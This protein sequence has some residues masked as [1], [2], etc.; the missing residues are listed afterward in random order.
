[1]WGHS[2]WVRE[3]LEQLEGIKISKNNFTGDVEF[4]LPSDTTITTPQ[5]IKAFSKSPFMAPKVITQT[6]INQPKH[7]YLITLNE[8]PPDDISYSYTQYF[9]RE[10]IIKETKSDKVFFDQHTIEIWSEKEIDIE[11]LTNNELITLKS[12]NKE[13]KNKAFGGGIKSVKKVDNQTLL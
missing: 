11:T 2:H 13:T 9:I 7:R 1:M 4:L 8:T 6:I 5:I 12:A 10:Q 3:A